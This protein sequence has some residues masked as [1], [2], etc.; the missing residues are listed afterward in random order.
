MTAITKGAI[1]AIKYYKHVVQS[2]EKFIQKCRPE[3]KIPGL[4]VIDS[5][6][7]QSRHQF[8][9]AKDVFAPRFAKNVLVTFYHLYKCAEEEKVQHLLYYYA[10]IRVLLRLEFQFAHPILNVTLATDQK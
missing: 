2:V 8:G 7:R 5:I 1:R 10:F 9:A 6:V 4:Y 3:Y